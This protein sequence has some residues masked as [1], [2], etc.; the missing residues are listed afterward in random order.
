MSRT[1]ELRRKLLVKEFQNQR[2]KCY[3]CGCQMKLPVPGQKPELTT[4]TREHMIP[5]LF[6]GTFGKGNIKAACLKC[7]NARGAAMVKSLETA[8]PKGVKPESVIRNP[9]NERIP[10]P[11]LLAQEQCRVVPVVPSPLSEES[12]P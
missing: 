4:A 1:P 8:R 10:G 11:L 5:K 7:N 9:R 2:G 3:W 6:G 12:K